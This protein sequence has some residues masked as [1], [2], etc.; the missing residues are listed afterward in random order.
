MAAHSSQLTFPIA[1]LM[2]IFKRP[3][4]GYA[5]TSVSLSDKRLHPYFLRTV[6]PD[7]IQ[8]VLMLQV[9]KQFGWDYASI[10][11]TNSGYGISARDALIRQAAFANLKT[12]VGVGHALA[13]STSLTEVEEILVSLSQKVGSRVVILFTDPAHSR[14]ILQATKNKGLT[15]RFVWLASDYWANSMEIVQG[16]EEEAVGALTV[17]IRS[18]FVQSFNNFM[19]NLNMTN[20]NGI[21]DDWFEEFYQTIHKC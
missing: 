16:Y 10:I 2:N 19:M 1:E 12:C 15:G 11:Y 14:L 20:R 8:V 4:I 5:T 18:E 7:D 6:P 21:P 13:Y 3:L 9:M 17:Q